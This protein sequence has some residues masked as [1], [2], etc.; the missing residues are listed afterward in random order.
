MPP[1]EIRPGV[2]FDNLR[3]GMTRDRVRALIGAPE[4]TEVYDYADGSRVES[5]GYADNTLDLS[6]A[7][8]HDWLLSSITVCDTE[9]VLAG[10]RFIGMPEKELI[11]RASQTAVGRITL[12]DDFAESGR[13]YSCDALGLSFWVVDGVVDSIT[14]MPLY[15]ASGNV[16]RWPKADA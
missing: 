10:Q 8:D 2:G 5:W 12:E 7:S 4:S 3:L 14:L 6:F 11:A 15:D 13:D 9:A 16:P 1:R